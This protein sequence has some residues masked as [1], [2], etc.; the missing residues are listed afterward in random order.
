MHDLERHGQWPNLP[1]PYNRALREAVAYILTRFE[2]VGLIAAGSILR[3][4]P[5]ATSDL[6]IYVIHL[7]PFRQR[8]QKYFCGVPAEIFVNPPAAIEKYFESEQAA[9]RPLTAHMLATGHVLL[10]ADPVVDQLCTRAA[11]LLT[12][13]P[14]VTVAQF[15]FSRYMSATLYEDATDMVQRDPATA[16]MLLSQAVVAMLQYFFL[17]RRSFLPRSKGL[18][19]H[20]TAVDPAL[21][22]AGRDFFLAGSL[23]ERLEWA[24]QIA[25]RTIGT[26][27]FFEWE[28]APEAVPPA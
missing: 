6:D 1:E 11:A 26:R 18:F 14:P 7:A 16:N 24:A 27:G 21:A 13:T 4:T 10:A 20:M 17:A 2:P 12:Q 22:Q 15:T 23:D 28:S 19:E 8:V 9:S 5:D 25:D 3:G